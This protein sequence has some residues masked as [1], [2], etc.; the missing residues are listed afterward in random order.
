MYFCF[1]LRSCAGI[2]LVNNHR[3]RA[4]QQSQAHWADMTWPTPF[5]LHAC[6]KLDSGVNG[7]SSGVMS[8]AAV[9]EEKRER[10]GE[11]E[12]EGWGRVGFVCCSPC[13]HCNIQ[14]VMW[15]QDC[16]WHSDITFIQTH[17]AGRGEGKR[18]RGHYSIWIYRSLTLVDYRME[19]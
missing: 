13:K 19:L 1:G 5:T 10:G 12:R 8:K 4:G 7:Q 16:G 3:S 2:V 17:G 9:K 11:R 6:L 15:W 14:T 18:R